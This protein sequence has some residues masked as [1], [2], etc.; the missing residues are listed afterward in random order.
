M[1]RLWYRFRFWFLDKYGERTSM[2][3]YTGHGDFIE[4]L[5]WE[6]RGRFHPCDSDE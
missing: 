5:G 3:Y 1:R 2:K 6:F 4:V